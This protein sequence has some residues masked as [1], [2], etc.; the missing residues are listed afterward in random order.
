MNGYYISLTQ[1]IR[2]YYIGCTCGCQAILSNIRK[3][4]KYVT[5]QSFHMILGCHENLSYCGLHTFLT[6]EVLYVS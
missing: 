3:C 4:K 2:T 6:Y 5:I 1:R